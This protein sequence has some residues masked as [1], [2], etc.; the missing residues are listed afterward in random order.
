MGIHFNFAPVVDINTN[1]KNPIIGNRSFGETKDNVTVRALALMKGLQDEGV[2]AT[3]KHFPG[4]GDTSTDSHHTLPVVN[5]DRE[6]L[7]E[8]E[9]FPYKELIKNGLSSIMVA[10]L[11]VPSLEPR[12]NYPT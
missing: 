10:H 12:K 1:P 4:H 2:F 7:N 8:V 11:N 9:L 3:A 5:F 6:R